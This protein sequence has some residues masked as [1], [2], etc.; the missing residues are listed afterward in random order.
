[1]NPGHC[2]HWKPC[3]GLC[4]ASMVLGSCCLAPVPEEH[5]LTSGGFS[6]SSGNP[7]SVTAGISGGPTGS[8]NSGASGE[9]ATGGATN[10]GS[11]ASTGSG[12]TGGNSSAGVLGTSTG[13]P[14][15]ASSGGGTS[16]GGMGAG[17]SGGSSGGQPCLPISGEITE[18]L[19]AVRVPQL[20]VIPFAEGGP[21]LRHV[22]WI[23]RRDDRWPRPVQSLP[24]QRRRSLPRFSERR[25]LPADGDVD[26]P[27]HGR[28]GG[29]AAFDLV[30][31]RSVRTPDDHPES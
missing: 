13:Q 19:T 26:L 12:A 17:S 7:T 20:T 31:K 24:A 2:G 28:G 15:T 10:G 11:D 1:M 23:A 25:G 22:C 14:P 6:V 3:W 5:A 27:R 16:T 8:S 18:F 9:Q 21:P 30:A 29:A 4:V